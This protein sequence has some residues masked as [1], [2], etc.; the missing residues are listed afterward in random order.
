MNLFHT[1]KCDCI[2]S[3]SSLIEKFLVDPLVTK[4]QVKGTVTG[5]DTPFIKVLNRVTKERLDGL[6]GMEVDPCVWEGLISKYDS[7]GGVVK[8]ITEIHLQVP[9]KDIPENVL[10]PDSLYDIGNSDRLQDLRT[11]LGTWLRDNDYHGTVQ[12]VLCEGKTKDCCGD[13]VLCGLKF[14]LSALPIGLLPWFIVVRNADGTT[15]TVNFRCV[16]PFLKPEEVPTSECGFEKLTVNM[17]AGV[18]IAAT[19]DTRP[20]SLFLNRESAEVYQ[21]TG[22]F[23]RF[24]RVY[25]ESTGPPLV[26][27]AE[28]FDTHFNTTSQL[29]YVWN[30]SNWCDNVFDAASNIDVS[31]V[32]E[33]GGGVPLSGGI[34]NA[35]PSTVGLY[36]NLLG[37]GSFLYDSNSLTSPDPS[38]AIFI[39]ESAGNVFIDK[40]FLG[41]GYYVE[42]ATST[43]YQ[44][45]S[46]IESNWQLYGF[47]TFSHD[48]GLPDVQLTGPFTHGQ[49]YLDLGT[50]KLW[51][52]SDVVSVMAWVER[53]TDCDKLIAPA[54]VADPGTKVFFCPFTGAFDTNG[55]GQSH[56]VNTD[57][58]QVWYWSDSANAFVKSQRFVF[59]NA[60]APTFVLPG[61]LHD[62]V[63]DVLYAYEIQGTLLDPTF[64][65]HP[66]GNVV[67]DNNPGAAVDVTTV[68]TTLTGCYGDE[69]PTSPGVGD[70]FLLLSDKNLY[71]Y[72]GLVWVV[73]NLAV[74]SS[75]VPSGYSATQFYFDLESKGLYEFIGT[76]GKP[77]WR[78]QI[79]LCEYFGE[80]T[81]L[82][83][84]NVCFGIGGIPNIASPNTSDEYIDISTNDVYTFTG[85]WGI[86]GIM[87]TGVVLPGFVPG[88]VGVYYLKTDDYR[89]FRWDGQVWKEKE[90]RPCEYRSYTGSE[91]T[92]TF[93]PTVLPASSIYYYEEATD[94]YYDFVGSV[95]VA[96]TNIT[97]A[98][99]VPGLTTTPTVGDVW[100]F[101]SDGDDFVYIF[102]AAL[103]W[104]NLG[105]SIVIGSGSTGTIFSP[106]E[107]GCDE[108]LF[109]PEIGTVNVCEI[110]V[111]M[112]ACQLR[113][114]KHFFGGTLPSGVYGVE[115][116][117]YY[118]NG[119]QEVDSGCVFVDCCLKCLLAECL[120]KDPDLQIHHM[121][122]ALTF[123][124]SCSSCDCTSVEGLYDQLLTILNRAVTDKKVTNCT[125]C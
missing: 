76:A 100:V 90:I 80:D 55:S 95:W 78:L 49:A 113:L 105:P 120:A 72:N 31:S 19:S 122:E 110:G 86:T 87:L 43:L 22:A 64:A 56:Y 48:T 69:L 73:E 103:T 50:G 32:I 21:W 112:S 111:D 71:R 94:E 47:G 11:A 14:N 85:T 45:N 37:Q 98:A 79:Y 30:G 83:L 44:F 118:D 60:G 57:T 59:Y 125:K 8:Y 15:G 23:W 68:A 10:A 52:Y 53:G 27:G 38:D 108:V 39:C 51:I 92:P 54:V 9:G 24:I 104:E 107:C 99:T 36:N 3:Q 119:D 114:N 6:S 26:E 81:E 29:I 35:S 17:G 115:V 63:N 102:S 58:N 67:C 40:S 66:I 16:S 2:V 74:L 65:L 101:Q 91:I 84:T 88:A 12:T 28:I 93:T 20:N 18:P 109:F 106:S 5:C 124:G 89:F 4:I 46:T 97:F 96:K 25:E 70:T 123:V 121:Y 82:E 41:F 117:I 7:C 62:T 75:G 61:F 77:Q 1:D 34:A 33:C 42:R 116:R 13:D